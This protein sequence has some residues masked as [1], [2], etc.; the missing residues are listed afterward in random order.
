MA[1]SGGFAFALWLYLERSIT[2][3]E[4]A[5]PYEWVTPR[6]VRDTP[7]APRTAPPLQ[8]ER[9]R[10]APLSLP[11]EVHLWPYRSLPRSGFVIFIGLTCSFLA[12][13]L[14]ALIGLTALWVVLPFLAAAVWA[15]WFAL[16]R[17]Y[18]DGEILEVLR[19]SHGDMHLSRRVARRQRGRAIPA[20]NWEANPY[21]VR[22]R[23]H[24]KPLPDYLTLEGG[25]R[26][27]ELGAFLTPGERRR[28][29]AELAILLKAARQGAIP[30]T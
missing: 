13:P 1:T 23:T 14:T 22:I 4:P 19:I 30:E 24:E 29:S 8:A 27:V 28:L 11:A 10:D 2:N 26:S 6:T 12:L 9:L 25:P 3:P 20:Q 16:Q 17:S 5:M 7:D 18:R 15:I 21:W